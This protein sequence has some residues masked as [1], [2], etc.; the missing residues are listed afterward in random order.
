MELKNRPPVSC[1]ELG[2]TAGLNDDSDRDFG[3]GVDASLGFPAHRNHQDR[4]REATV[5]TGSRRPRSAALQ[6]RL[7]LIGGSYQSKGKST[8]YVSEVLYTDTLTGNCLHTM[9]AQLFLTS[10][11]LK[12]SLFGSP[13]FGRWLV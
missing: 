4:R 2:R 11:S 1:S 12:I 3:R 6:Q 5:P 7:S 13:P 9:N 8:R 10:V